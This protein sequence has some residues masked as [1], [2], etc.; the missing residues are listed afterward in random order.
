LGYGY[1]ATP[2][3]WCMLFAATEY[4]DERLAAEAAFAAAEVQQ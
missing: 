4:M 2:G 1:L 3:G